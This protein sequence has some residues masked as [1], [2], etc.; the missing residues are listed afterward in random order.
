MPSNRAHV[1]SRPEGKYRFPPAKLL[2]FV[3]RSNSVRL[4]RR[5]FPPLAH[6]ASVCQSGSSFDS[7]CLPPE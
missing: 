4:V 1:C 6:F 5:Y 2:A 3:G 7:N